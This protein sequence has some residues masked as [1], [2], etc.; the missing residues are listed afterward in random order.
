M[1]ERILT[2]EKCELL[3]HASYDGDY[4]FA[5]D[6]IEDYEVI[7]KKL[8]LIRKYSKAT[9]IK[10]YVLVGFESTGA[11][12]IANAFKRIDL[13]MR[14]KCLPYIM[15]YKDYERSPYRGMYVT[16]ARWCN[17]PS[18][19]KKLSFREFVERNGETSAAARYAA[20]FERDH[21][22]IAAEYYDL[23]WGD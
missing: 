21:P 11:E 8:K 14:Y 22:G 6:N 15:R 18:F 3:F 1:D 2:E 19:A 16:L 23:K 4:T 12:D 17:Q 5:F 10:F 13:L 7:H 9:N 20:E